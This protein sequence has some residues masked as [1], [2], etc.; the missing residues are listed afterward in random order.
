MRIYFIAA[1]WI[2]GAVG[3][4]AALNLTPVALRDFG[5]LWGAGRAIMAGIDPYHVEAFKLFGEQQLGVGSYNFTYP[6]HALL[7]FMPFSLLPA[8]PAFIVWNLF[9]IALFYFAARP[10]MPK[11]LPPI[12][13]L[14][15]PPVFIN[16]NFGQTGLITAA[17]FLFAFR[18][19]GLSAAALT[20]KPHMGFLVLLALLRDRRALAIAVGASLLLT[21][22]SALLFGGWSDF[23]LHA[24]DYQARTLFNHTQDVWVVQATTPMIGYGV[25]GWLLY[26]IG[27]IYLLSRNFGVFTAATA[28][29]LISP[30]GLHYDMAAVCLGF[31]ILLFTNW[32]A[33]PMW[34]RAI[35]TLA[36]L[37]PVIVGFGTW[38]VPPIL[39]IGLLVQCQWLEGVRL[40]VDV[41]KPGHRRLRF[42]TEPRPIPSGTTTNRPGDRAAVPESR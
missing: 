35:A 38:L 25:W 18:G 9:S 10:L 34:H 31:S 5:S 16:S 15:V 13:A 1:L 36:Y 23:F 39:L 14:L 20:F 41:G 11:G 3:P 4:I 12:L 6:P 40:K 27:A 26:A 21:L 33:M 22:A 24:R 29:F 42:E 28:T 2:L 32:D 7:L 30:Y 19:S 17:L 37:T 8:V